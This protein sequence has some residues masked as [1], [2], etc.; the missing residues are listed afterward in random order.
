[1]CLFL[2]ED[3]DWP[4]EKKCWQPPG[5]EWPLTDNEETGTGVL[6]PQET[7]FSQ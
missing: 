4:R 3:G 1:M 5:A 7:E 6:Q 2:V